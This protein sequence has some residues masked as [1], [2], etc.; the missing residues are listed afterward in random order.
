M[1]RLV[2][3][4]V[5]VFLTTGMAFAAK[6]A[7]DYFAMASRLYDAK[8]YQGAAYSFEAG[9]TLE[10]NSASGYQNL[11]NCYYALGRQS[12]ASDAYQMSLK[13]NPDNPQLAAFLKGLKPQD[14][15]SVEANQSVENETS[16]NPPV[17]AVSTA[18]VSQNAASSSRAE[19]KA[20]LNQSTW[21]RVYGGYDLALLGDFTTGIDAE[22]SLLA[23]GGSSTG[24]NGIQAGAELGFA[25]DQGNAFSLSIENV[26]TQNESYN[27]GLTGTGAQSAIFQPDLMGAALNYYAYISSSKAAKTYLTLGVG[28]Y[29]A[30]VGFSGVDPT[31]ATPSESGTFSDGAVGETF[32]LGQDFEIGD[33]LGIEISIRGRIVTFN[34]VTSPTLDNGGTQTGSYAIVI[35]SSSSSS[36]GPIGV[37]PTSSIGSTYRYMVL[38]Y[39]GLDADFSFNFYF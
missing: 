5:F 11:G 9:L 4:M 10:P 35:D 26:W 17:S 34:K 16:I 39:S 6:T 13:L 32:G 1:K 14:A 8:D 23:S 21:V 19:M 3:V 12:D 28:Y 7:S 27:N 25:I 33:S 37:M 38:D 24:G 29:E 36:G 20:A 22:A 30:I 18:P 2:W 31:L 15:I